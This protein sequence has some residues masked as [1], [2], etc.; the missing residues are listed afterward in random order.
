MVV[1]FRVGVGSGNGGGTWLGRQHV[2]QA[3]AVTVM[4]AIELQLC[5]VHCEKRSGSIITPR[6]RELDRGGR[7]GKSWGSGRC[8]WCGFW[9]WSDHRHH[10]D[11]PR[12][13][14]SPLTFSLPRSLFSLHPSDLAVF[15][16]TLMSHSSPRL[17]VKLASCLSIISPPAGYNCPDQ[18][19]L[20]QSITS[21][22]VSPSRQSW[23]SRSFILCGRVL[24]L[25]R[26]CASSL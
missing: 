14:H 2:S 3:I 20:L 22:I 25:A 4:S 18:R 11:H 17:N 15:G 23:L 24:R 26:D 6:R 5:H 7:K 13:T 1:F 9:W 19:D 10:R 8:N 16:A 12:A 21:L